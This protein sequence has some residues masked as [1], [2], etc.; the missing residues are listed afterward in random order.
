MIDEEQKEEEKEEE[1]EIYEEG[2]K[3]NLQKKSPQGILGAKNTSVG[4]FLQT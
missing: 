1:E 4:F 3:S 2:A